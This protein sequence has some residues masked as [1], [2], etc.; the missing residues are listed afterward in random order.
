MSLRARSVLALAVG[1]ALG[2]TLTLGS[3]VRADRQT[4]AQAQEPLPADDVRL[5]VEVL[6]RVRAEYV[7]E[8]DE[9]TLIENAVRGMV[10]GL[11]AH[12]AFLDSEEYRE[13]RIS[14]AG[15]YSGVGLEVAIKDGEVCIVSPIDG[16]PAAKAGIEAGDIILSVDGVPVNRDSLD[17]TIE[18]MRGETGTPV[19]LGIRGLGDRE[20]RSITL[21]REMIQVASVNARMLEPGLGYI[22]ISHFSETTGG[23]LEKAAGNLKRDNHGKLDG[24]VLDLRNNPGGLLDAATEVSDL[25][26]EHGLIVSADGRVEDARFSMSAGPGDV[27]DGKPLVVLVNHGSAS[28]SEIV[29]GALQD[30]ARAVVVGT[31]TYG[32]GSV[33]TVMPLSDGRAIKLT[34]SRYRTPSGRSIQEIG[35]RPDVEVLREVGDSTVITPSGIPIEEGDPALAQAVKILKDRQPILQSQAR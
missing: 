1:M 32:K 23:D 4:A 13:V 7:D 8:V 27:L 30:N 19:V 5:L 17:D 11:D 25:F 24:L 33:Q 6:E 28:A 9:H 21:M 12:S 31:N 34:T 10:A 14:T 2:L 20:V 18:G 15:A 35:I 22:R 29:A 3:A 26:L 16:G